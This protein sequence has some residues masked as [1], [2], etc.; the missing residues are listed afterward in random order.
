MKL[1]QGLLRAVLRIVTEHEGIGHDVL[2]EEVRRRGWKLTPAELEEVLQALRDGG[3]TR[4]EKV[5]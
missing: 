1:T 3:Y 5:H 2:L 4:Q